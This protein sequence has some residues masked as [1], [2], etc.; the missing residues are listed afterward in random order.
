MTLALTGIG[1]S[2]NRTVA[3]GAVALLQRGPIRVAQRLVEPAQVNQEVHRLRTAVEK[4]GRQLLET[5][6]RIPADTPQDI[7]EFIDAHL[8]MLEDR[9]LFDAAEDLIVEAS[10]AAECVPPSR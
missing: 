4:A 8:L 2:T 5:R 6:E 1:I 3:I 10:C 7:A 9:T